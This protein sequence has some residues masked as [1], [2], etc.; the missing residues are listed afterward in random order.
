MDKI[1][2]RVQIQLDETAVAQTCE[3]RDG[4]ECID[5]PK[6]QSKPS[7]S[8]RALTEP[9]PK[10]DYAAD[11][12]KDVMRGRKREVEHFVAKESQHTDHQQNCSAQHDIDLC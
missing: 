6:N 11:Q 7:R 9:S 12:V 2:M 8:N 4:H 1:E 5:R 3:T 10:G